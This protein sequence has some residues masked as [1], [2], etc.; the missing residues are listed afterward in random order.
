MNQPLHHRRIR[1]SN[2]KGW[3]SNTLNELSELFVRECALTPCTALDIGAAH[4]IATIPA[5]ISGARVIA[6]DS[7][8]EHLERLAQLT[9]A[10]CRDRLQLLP[11]R[12]PRD[13]KLAANSLDLAHAS[14]VFHFLTGRQLE[15]AAA[16][17]EHALRPDGK[18]YILAATPYMK[19]FEPFI[20]TYEA[21][22]QQQDPWPGWIPNV[23]DYS[24]HRLLSN[25]PKSIHLLDETVLRR[26][27]EG[28][29]FVTE[30]CWYFR[31]RDLPKSIQ[32]DGRENVAYIAR[33]I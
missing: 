24:T 23:R 18:V 10:E 19:T 25:L 20:S 32:L 33:K 30:A 21:R 16:T 2:A 8:R 14:N 5:L 27:F 11:G 9:P 4:G 6:S 28:A 13:T 3:T 7:A 22:V 29:G 17:L 26:V 15:Q 12:F 1:T 31:R